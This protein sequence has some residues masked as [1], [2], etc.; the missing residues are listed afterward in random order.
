[1][2]CKFYRGA[3]K[4]K[5]IRKRLTQSRSWFRMLKWVACKYTQTMVTTAANA[6]TCIN[7]FYLFRSRSS[8]YGR[9]SPIQD[10]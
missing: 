8:N 4:P 9:R 3:D 6:I 7:G 2:G 10:S 5:K 1:M